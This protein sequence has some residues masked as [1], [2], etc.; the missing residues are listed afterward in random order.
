MQWLRF[1]IGVFRCFS[2]H[3]LFKSK[4]IYIYKSF[5]LNINKEYHRDGFNKVE[6]MV[7]INFEHFIY[8]IYSGVVENEEIVQPSL[9]DLYQFS[10][11]MWHVGVRRDNVDLPLKGKAA[12]YRYPS[13]G[14]IITKEPL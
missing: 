2:L 9:V 8:L 12:L 10:E 1:F 13:P 6:L 3:H 4:F 14:S 5:K 7:M 11:W